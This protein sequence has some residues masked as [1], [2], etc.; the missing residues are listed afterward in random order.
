MVNRLAVCQRP[1]QFP[2]GYGRHKPYLAGGRLRAQHAGG[3]HGDLPL[4]RES[5]WGESNAYSHCYSNCDPDRNSY[6]Y[7]YADG[8]SNA[9]AYSDTD[10]KACSDSAASSN[11]AAAAVALTGIVKA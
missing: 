2:H 11:A 6:S 8:N 3:G 9:D 7:S 10:A 5:L 4:P 1:P